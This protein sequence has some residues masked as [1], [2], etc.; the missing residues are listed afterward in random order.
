V[1]EGTEYGES[2]KLGGFFEADWKSTLT[3]RMCR[4]VFLSANPFSASSIGAGASL[5]G[6]A[7]SLV[8]DERTSNNILTAEEEEKEKFM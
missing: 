1:E 8:H 7:L 3:S 5:I 2:W 6:H 4:G